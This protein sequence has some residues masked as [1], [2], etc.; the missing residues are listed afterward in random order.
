[1]QAVGADSGRHPLI[2]PPVLDTSAGPTELHVVPCVDELG[3]AQ[4]RTTDVRND[5]LDLGSLP[6]GAVVISATFRAPA[7]DPAGLHARMQ[8][9][10]AKRDATQ[11]T[12][13]RSAGST[14][15][16]PAGFSST[17]RADDTHEL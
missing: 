17:G 4:I 13:E 14:F 11:P 12:R 6:D 16:N 9:Q 10:I 8:D 1:M 2:V 5:V 15:R 7:G 3:N